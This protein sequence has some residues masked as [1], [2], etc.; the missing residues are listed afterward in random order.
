MEMM[1][2]TQTGEVRQDERWWAASAHAGALLLAFLTSWMAGVAGMVAGLVVYLLMRDRSAFVAEHARE[3]FN[4][5]LTLFLFAAGLAV[6]ALLLL[7]ATVLT[8]GLG[9]VLTLPVGIVL[10]VLAGIAAVVWL[11]CGIMATVKALDGQRWR[12]PFSLRLL[13]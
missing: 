2:P 5:N 11:V 6:A 3:A 4:F 1:E 10:L 8:L 13:R 7:G 12:Y 9:A